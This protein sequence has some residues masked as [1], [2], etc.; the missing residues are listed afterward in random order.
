MHQVSELK[1]NPV[2]E[3]LFQV[4]ADRLQNCQFSADAGL[5]NTY[6][7]RWNPENRMFTLQKPTE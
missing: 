4:G 3:F 1:K 5:V 6:T 7:G 2:P